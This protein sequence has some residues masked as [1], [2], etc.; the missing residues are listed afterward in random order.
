MTDA[1]RI[2]YLRSAL[3]LFGLIAVALWPL[4]QLLPAEF[5]WHDVRSR[6]Y[7]FEMI[8]SIYFVLGIFLLI[9][10]RNPLEH[11]SLIW[12]TI[13]SSV[14]HGGLMLVQSFDDRPRNLAH[15]WGDVP[16]L[17]FGAILLA[18]LTPRKVGNSRS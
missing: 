10:S 2:L 1:T 7:Y 12:F 17:L 3:A 14:A 9:A 13:W 8:C 5:C 4:S 15:L 6:S 11:R 16:L 18:W